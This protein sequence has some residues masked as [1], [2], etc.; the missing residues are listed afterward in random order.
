MSKQELNKTDEL[1]RLAGEVFEGAPDWVKWA[2][3]DSAMADHNY[4][5]NSWWYWFESMPE[6]KITYNIWYTH[7]SE[8]AHC[9]NQPETDLPWTETILRRSDYE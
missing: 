2:A 9:K 4:L 5:K 8:K 1:K 7:A 3:M 6:S